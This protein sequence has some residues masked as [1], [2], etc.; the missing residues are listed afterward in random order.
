MPELQP[1][2]SS[3]RLARQSTT[4]RSL[5]GLLAGLGVTLS[6]AQVDDALAKKR[7]KKKKSNPGPTCAA[8]EITCPSGSIAPCCPADQVCCDI[9]RI[10]CCMAR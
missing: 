10:G 8:G 2:S 9:N 5:A 6:G 4:R 7:K 3:I 1:G